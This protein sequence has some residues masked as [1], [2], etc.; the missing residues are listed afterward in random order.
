MARRVAAA[1]RRVFIKSLIC[2]F[3][4][5]V[6]AVAFVPGYG[7]V[8]VSAII[9]IVI[10]SEPV[11]AEFFRHFPV[12]LLL[13]FGVRS[14]RCDERCHIVAETLELAFEHFVVTY[15][16][17]FVKKSRT[18]HAGDENGLLYAEGQ[19]LFL[20]QY[21]GTD[22]E[23]V[24]ALAVHDGGCAGDETGI[25]AALQHGIVSEEQGMAAVLLKH[26]VLR[27]EAVYVG[28][29][30]VLDHLVDVPHERFEALDEVVLEGHEA[31]EVQVAA[32]QRLLVVEDGA[33]GHT[34]VGVH[35][36]AVHDEV[37]HRTA[38]GTVDD[39]GKEVCRGNVVD[40][41]VVAADMVKFE[42]RV[43]EGDVEDV[44][45]QLVLLHECNGIE[46]GDGACGLVC[47]ACEVGHLL[48]FTLGHMVLHGAGDA[49]VFAR[50]HRLP[51]Q[52]GVSH[53]CQQCAYGNRCQAMGR[54]GGTG[55]AAWQEP[56]HDSN[57]GRCS[58]EC[59]SPYEECGDFAAEI[60]VV[61]AVDHPRQQGDDG[62][63]SYSGEGGTP[64]VAQTER[65]TV[66]EPRCKGEHQGHDTASHPFVE[67]C[68]E[69]EA[70]G[71]VNPCQ[72]Q[73]TDVVHCLG[74]GG[75]VVLARY[76]RENFAIGERAEY[77]ECCKSCGIDR[78]CRQTA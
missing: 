36:R 23:V 60:E 34:L 19:R 17:K 7:L 10:R 11:V 5:S 6:Y 72:R 52:S 66:D 31:D 4:E 12:G 22:E 28:E 47:G 49:Y 18:S 30:G 76:L 8:D 26:G 27:I 33:D 32:C 53:G 37:L 39:S 24:E 57:R 45:Q 29:D 75:D 2:G 58:E 13:G 63:E 54:G 21:V 40:T 35:P 41:L 42:F 56:G 50:N 9:V 16:R 48:P 51:C 62:E 61:A 77:V 69:E 1:T 73:A 14:R 67:K 44:F 70:A 78:P 55:L 25:A 46:C 3:R 43:V 64:T 68:E 65:Q 20:L 38:V 59:D 71:P 74:V 15:L